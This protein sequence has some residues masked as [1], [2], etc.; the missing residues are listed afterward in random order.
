MQD[1]YV[2]MALMI[3]LSALLGL[4]AYVL[5]RRLHRTALIALMVFTAGFMIV[6]TSWL[7]DG[8]WMARLLPWSALPILGNWMVPA[9]GILVGLAWRQIPG[10]TFRKGLTLVP[11]AGLALYSVYGTVFQHPPVCRD[12]W[13]GNYCLQTTH[14]SCSPAAAATLL[15]IHNIKATEDEMALLCLTRPEGTTQHGLYRALKI[16]TAGTPW[17]VEPIRGEVSDLRDKAPI[18]LSVGVTDANKIGRQ[19]IDE[20]GWREGAGHS[21]VLLKFRPD[22]YIDIAD[23]AATKGVEAWTLTDLHN[24]WQGEGFRLVR[25]Q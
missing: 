14:A 7:Q 23:P 16:K 4:G 13:V 17:D 15:R 6:F 3:L 10:S 20:W 24:L 11:L 8:V 2:A 5:A 22:G 9:A 25:R 21:V 18:I 19:Y 12:Q 1:L